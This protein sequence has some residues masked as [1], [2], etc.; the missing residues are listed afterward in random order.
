MQW[1]QGEDRGSWKRAGAK[2]GPAEEK[3]D[4]TDLGTTGAPYN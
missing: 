3:V 1:V 4:E 2:V